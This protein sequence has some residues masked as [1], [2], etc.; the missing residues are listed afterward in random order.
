MK[1]YKH[2]ISKN[3][4]Q[5]SIKKLTVHFTHKYMFYLNKYGTSQIVSVQK[6]DSQIAHAKYKNQ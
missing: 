3:L 4:Y 2:V 1:Y 6:R 5:F